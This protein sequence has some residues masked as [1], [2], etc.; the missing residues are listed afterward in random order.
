[1][2]RRKILYVALFI[3]ALSTISASKTYGATTAMPGG[4]VVI[5]SHA[6]SLD[7][8]NDPKNENEI[9]SAIVTGGD[10]YV[11]TYDN[12]WVNNSTSVTINANILPSVTYKSSTGIESNFTAGDASSD[13]PTVT[14]P[15]QIISIE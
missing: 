7:Y 3:A 2:R 10:V 9:S 11:K 5:G 8:A 1:M 13:T 12:T 15:L 14:D 6:F 4:T